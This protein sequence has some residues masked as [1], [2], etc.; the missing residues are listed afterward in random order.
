M[1]LREV[2]FALSGAEGVAGAEAPAAALAASYL[3]AYT[4]RV[5]LRNGNVAAELGVRASGKPHLLLDAHIDQI[6]MVVTDITEDGFLRVGSVGGLDCRLLPGQQV[7]I[8]GKETIC[9][10]VSAIPPH[11][12]S[13]DTQKAAKLEALCIDTG[14]TG[15]ALRKLVSRGDCVRF[16]VS[17]RSLLGDRITG[18]ALD[19]RSGVASI[20]YALELL[21]GETLPC[22]LTVLFSTQEELGE[23]GAQIGAYEANPDLAIAV[24]VSFGLTVDEKPEDCGELGKGPMIG[25]SPTLSRSLSNAL[26]AAAEAEQIPYQL[27]IMPGLTSTNAD[28]FSVTRCGAKAC[29]VSIPLK[30][31]HTPVEVIACGDV[32]Q[33]GRLLAA[34]VRRCSAC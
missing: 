32:E 24:D 4:D 16:A 10:T 11:L 6:G 23:R 2:L 15:E 3:R 14:Y 18:C 1:N 22:S 25:I 21:Q 19:D 33:T 5:E 29:T 27:E 7:L 34:Y 13:G 17:P 12:Q 8:A 30:Y 28:R 9:G 20:L 26:I 31:M